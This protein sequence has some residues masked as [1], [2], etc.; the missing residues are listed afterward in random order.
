[1]DK[2]ANITNSR[3]SWPSDCVENHPLAAGTVTMHS[4]FNWLWWCVLRVAHYHHGVWSW[5]PDFDFPFGLFVDSYCFADEHRGSNVGGPRLSKDNL[6]KNHRAL[7]RHVNTA[8]S[9]VLVYDHI[10]TFDDEVE[11][12]WKRTPWSGAKLL[13]IGV[14]PPAHRPICYSMQV[15]TTASIPKPRQLPDHPHD[16]G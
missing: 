6:L 12:I 7:A 11:R 5:L 14:R 3:G 4:P 1:M 9:L 13:W 10:L 16:R 8:A 2:L 15:L